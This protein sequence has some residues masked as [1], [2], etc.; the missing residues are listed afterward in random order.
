M[1]FRELGIGD[2]FDWIEEGSP[3]NSFFLRCKKISPRRYVDTKGVTYQVRTINVEVFHVIPK[4][5][6]K[7]NGR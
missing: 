5:E 2:T 3:Y 7:D 1:R 6:T 4:E